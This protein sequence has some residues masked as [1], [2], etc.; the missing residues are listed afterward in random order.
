[1]TIRGKVYEEIAVKLDEEIYK[2]A[3]LSLQAIGSSVEEFSALCLLKLVRYVRDI[4]DCATM[5][6][7]TL[8]QRIV[9]DVSEELELC[10]VNKPKNN[11]QGVEHE[12]CI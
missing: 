11:N 12:T 4:P 9:N 1:M 3:S 8:I 7:D 2:A 5:Q 10:Y 6:A